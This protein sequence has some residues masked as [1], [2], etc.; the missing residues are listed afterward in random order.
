M[1]LAHAAPLETAIENTLFD[2]L[3][4]SLERGDLT[5]A[6]DVARHLADLLGAD[7]S[8]SAEGSREQPC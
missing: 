4:S 6:S 7:S 2:L 5:I 1:D 8:P 3:A